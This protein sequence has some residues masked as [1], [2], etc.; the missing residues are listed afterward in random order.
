MCIN[1]LLYF[2]FLY[3]QTNLCTIYINKWKQEGK[4]KNRDSHFRGND[5]ISWE[6]MNQMQLFE[7][8][9]NTCNYL[10]IIAWIT[11]KALPFLKT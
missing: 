11:V 1:R 3:I 7:A 4:E 10:E 9:F 6:Y 5:C 8:Q 2:I